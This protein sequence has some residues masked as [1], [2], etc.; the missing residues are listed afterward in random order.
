MERYRNDELRIRF[1]VF[2]DGNFKPNLHEVTDAIG[3]NYSYFI[4]WKNDK[5][6]LGQRKLDA[7]E[8]FLESQNS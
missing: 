7:L 2:Y 8:A 4:R 5:L 3:I 1:T 6:D